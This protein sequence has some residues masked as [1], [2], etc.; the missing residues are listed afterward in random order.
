MCASIFDIYPRR[1][2]WAVLRD[3]NAVHEVHP[4]AKAV[5]ENRRIGSLGT[6]LEN[7]NVEFLTIKEEGADKA[8]D[9]GVQSDLWDRWMMDM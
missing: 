5:P 9:A 1:I 4:S 3:F 6:Y 7:F 8:D 2:P